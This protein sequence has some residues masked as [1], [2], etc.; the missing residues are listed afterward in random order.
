MSF[1]LTAGKP[2]GE[3]SL[4]AGTNKIWTG[5]PTLVVVLLGGFTTNFIWCVFLNLKNR[6][7]YEYLASHRRSEQAGTQSG[8][9]K[10]TAAMSELQIPRL[11]NYGFAALAGATWYFQ[12]FFYTMGATQMGRYDFASWTLHMASIIIFSTMW[13]WI[14]HEWR[15]AS[16]KAHGL[17]AAGIATLILSTIIIGCGTWLK[18][19]VGGGD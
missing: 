12:F 11:A 13:G 5:L 16:R 9:T 8:S 4:A 7:G 18:G 1:G 6:S 10:A 3:A 19:Q 17:I 15:G 14:L 2:I